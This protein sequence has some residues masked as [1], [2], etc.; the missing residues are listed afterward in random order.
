M[1]KR[2]LF[3][4]GETKKKRP[5]N[6]EPLIRLRC[7]QLGMSLGVCDRPTI[8]R[9]ERQIGLAPNE[10]VI[11]RASSLHRFCEELLYLYVANCEKM[12]FVGNFF[13]GFLGGTVKRCESF[14]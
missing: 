3:L 7:P 4:D 11:Q 12:F 13:M 5:Q 8:H 14:T 9:I 10:T 6:G 2:K 1:S